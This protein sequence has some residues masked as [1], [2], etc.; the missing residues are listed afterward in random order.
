MNIK[1][2]TETVKT[3][4]NDV[5]FV[6]PICDLFEISLQN[7]QRIIQNDPVLSKDWTKK[8]SKMIFGNEH[9]RTALSR[10]GFI[11]WIQLINPNN[12]KEDLREKLTEYQTMIF[13]YLYGETLIPNVTREYELE[14][15]KKNLNKEINNLMEQHKKAELEIKSL[16]KNNFAQL[17][18]DFPKDKPLDEL[19]PFYKKA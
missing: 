3:S 5:I 17:G 13:D 4:E 9:P 1:L 16:K 2:F 8:S 12:V 19:K 15:L 14:L 11:R 6:Q 10:K 7:Q 18:F